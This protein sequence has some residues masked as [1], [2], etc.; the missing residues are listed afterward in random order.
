MNS[1]HLFVLYL[2]F[3]LY[4]DICIYRAG[5]EKVA[6]ASSD[7]RS[8]IRELERGGKAGEM[9]LNNKEVNKEL[10]NQE[11]WYK[12][13][14]KKAKLRQRGRKYDQQFHGGQ[15]MK[16]VTNIDINKIGENSSN[17]YSLYD[18][19]GSRDDVDNDVGNLS[20]PD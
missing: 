4:V 7:L 15:R 12:R 3:T 18:S 5:V 2:Y 17:E 1:F 11:F 20:D 16:K 14:S 9:L 10:E 19:D 13:G 8:S 6:K